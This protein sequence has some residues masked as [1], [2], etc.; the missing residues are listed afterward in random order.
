M[1]RLELPVELFVSDVGSGGDGIAR[2]PDGSA[3]FV[4]G[5]LPGE[6]VLARP[7]GKGGRAELEQVLAPS[8]DRVAPPC[9]VF[10]EGCGGC[11]LQHWGDAPYAA[12][13]RAR[14]AETL[15]RAGAPD[16]P[17]AGMARTPP[18]TRRRADLALRRTPQGVVT[19]GFHARGAS[20]AMVLDLAECHILDP[21]LF[22]LLA[23]LRALLRGVPALRREGSAVVNLLDTGPDLLLRTDAPLDAAGRAALANFCRAQGLPR[24]AWALKDGPAEIAAQLG[25]VSVSFGGV[26]V[27]PPPGAFLQASPQGEAAIVEAVLQGLPQKLPGKARI[28]D[29]YA[30]IGTLS[31]PLATRARVL[32]VEGA[33]E[34][35]EALRNAAHHAQARVEVE[36]RDLAR[37]PLTP[38]ELAP[39]AAVVLDPPFA[40]AADQVAQLARSAVP[41][42]V[43]VSCNPAALARDAKA[44][45]GARFSVVA[46][47]PVDQFLW[48]TH[49]ESV[50]V[51]AR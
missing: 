22:A 9:P 34:A 25:P 48:S 49:L 24:I 42:V 38:Q 19:I 12:W 32:A 31:L 18:L 21:R 7:P 26:A 43:Y 35:A 44:L 47:T 28:A 20:G 39:F 1:D 3:C 17:V 16:A 37:R 40:G 46:A 36:R 6:R 33:A 2:L 14:L 45:L 50:V 8:T 30:G 13:K 23:P 10:L 41:R 29:L 11:T 5:A 4:A 27:T 51:F 15:S